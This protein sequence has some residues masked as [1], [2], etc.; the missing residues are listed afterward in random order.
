MS[1]ILRGLKKE[2][3]YDITAIVSVADDGGNSGM[4]R[5]DLDIL[6]PG[7][8]R[9]CLLALASDESDMN[10]ILN[11][12]F[13]EGWLKGQNIGNLILA[14]ASDLY[15]DFEEGIA[16]LSHILKVKGKVLPVTVDKIN[17]VAELE[18][19]NIVVGE[20]QIPLVSIKEGSPIKRVYLDPLKAQPTKQA[21][22]AIANADAILLGPGSLY[23]SI[24][25]NLLVSD[26][27]KSLEKTSAKLIYVS[28]LMTQPGETDGFTYEKYISVLE[29]YV[30]IDYS[31][32]NNRI[33]SEEI[34]IE[35]IED[36]SR[37]VISSADPKGGQSGEE[38]VESDF[39]SLQKGFVRHNADKVAEALRFIL[40]GEA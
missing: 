4:L 1:T 36:G 20:S 11:Y 25:P 37:Q 7:D 39:I 23:T 16:K 21:L 29:E 9:N 32:V 35:Y 13:K 8:V 17:L 14:A 3:D 34:L 28:S 2:E 22:N 19:G 31:L 26:I 18:N 38:L 30:N 24:I 27:C 6:P 40:Q 5:K 33:L 12:R 10:D 15:G